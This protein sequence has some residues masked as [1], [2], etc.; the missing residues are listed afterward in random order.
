MLSI[1]VSM[2]FIVF[3]ISSISAWNFLIASIFV[4]DLPLLLHFI[5][6]FSNILL[7]V[8]VHLMNSVDFCFFSKKKKKQTDIGVLGGGK[9]VH[10]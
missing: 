8:N 9:W 2:S 7:Y 3:F 6:Y 4:Q 1:E 10:W 5:S